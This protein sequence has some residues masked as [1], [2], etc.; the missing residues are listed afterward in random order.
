MTRFPTCSGCGAAIAWRRTANGKAMPLDADP[1]T[2][3]PAVDAAG[4]VVHTG[5]TVM[6]DPEVMVVATKRS[7]F[8]PDEVSDARPRHMPHFATCPNPPRPK[9]REEAT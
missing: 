4:N 3:D 7:L 2:G 1:A 8:D 9:R 6:G 5:Q